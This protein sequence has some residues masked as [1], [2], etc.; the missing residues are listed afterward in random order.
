MAKVNPFQLQKN[1][2]GVNYPVSK[3]ELIQQAQ[4]H[5]VYFCCK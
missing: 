5:K 3:E 1:L 4:Q 2:K